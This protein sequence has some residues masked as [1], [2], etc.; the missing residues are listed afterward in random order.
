MRVY[1]TVLFLVGAH[2]IQYILWL[3]RWIVGRVVQGRLDQAWLLAWAL[4]A[5]FGSLP[6]V[7]TWSQGLLAVNGGAPSSGSYGA[8]RLEPEEIRHQGLV[9]LGQIESEAVESLALSGGL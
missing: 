2:A 9:S 1:H 6:P 4:P 5:H 7:V 8:L 3:L